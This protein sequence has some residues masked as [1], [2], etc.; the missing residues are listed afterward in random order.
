MFL[1]G[2]DQTREAHGP[3]LR[4]PITDDP[5][6]GPALSDFH[7][8]KRPVVSSL[9]PLIYS[10]HSTKEAGRHVLG[11]EALHHL[12]SPPTPPGPPASRRDFSFQL[13]LALEL[14]GN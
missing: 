7:I 13:C 12:S 11:L 3:W 1:S 9:R 14:I 6:I 5:P 4:T 8:G 2:R 10:Q